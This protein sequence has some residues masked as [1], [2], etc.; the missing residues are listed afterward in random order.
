VLLTHG[1]FDEVSTASATQVSAALPSSGKQVATF[2]GSGSYMH[3]G[4]SS[5]VSEMAKSSEVNSSLFPRTE[6]R[7]STLAVG[8]VQQPGWGIVGLP[9]KV[10]TAYQQLSC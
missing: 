10:G 5:Q 7:Q 1:E 3:I 9:K 4:E 8:A 6:Q 2:K